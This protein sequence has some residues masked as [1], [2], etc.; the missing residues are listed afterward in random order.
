M[1]RTDWYFL[2]HG[3][4]EYNQKGLF[5]GRIDIPLNDVGRQQAEDARGEILAIGLVFDEVVT[6]PLVRAVE[7]AE[8]I[9]GIPKEQFRIDERIIE[10]GFGDFEGTSFRDPNS[11]IHQF[12]DDP[13]SYQPLGNGETFDA[14]LK[15]TEGFLMEMRER[16]LDVDNGKH[17]LIA[18]HGGAIR[19]LYRT[20]TGLA[21]S[22]F[23]NLRVGNCDLFHFAVIDGEIKECEPVLRHAD[24][25]DPHALAEGKK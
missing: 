2:R 25:Y 1:T 3:E 7:T 10:I 16:S 20:L 15:R 13:A 22:D 14:V 21:L 4:T 5:Q 23:W 11:P 8:I 18:T 24:P 19:S 12:N 6:S 17:I 9:S